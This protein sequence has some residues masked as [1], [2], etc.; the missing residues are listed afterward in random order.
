MVFNFQDTV[1][2]TVVAAL[3]VGVGLYIYL[4]LRLEDARGNSENR[5]FGGLFFFVYEEETCE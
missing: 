5:T 4:N 1:I 3:R 2:I